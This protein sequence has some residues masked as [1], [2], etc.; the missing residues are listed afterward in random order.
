MGDG[1]IS[2]NGDFSG[3]GATLIS[4]DCQGLVRGLVDE[5]EEGHVGGWVV[6]SEGEG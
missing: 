4:I 1:L 3:K 6:A 5:L 2:G